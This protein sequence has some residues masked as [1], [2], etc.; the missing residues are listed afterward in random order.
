MNRFLLTVFLCISWTPLAF[1]AGDPWDYIKDGA[2][3]P[4]NWGGTCGTGKKQSPINI[5][6]HDATVD[7][8]L[9]SFM[10]KNYDMAPTN[11]TFTAKNNGHSLV[12]VFPE[13]ADYGVSGG[14]LVGNY[15]THSFHFHWGSNNTQGPEHILDGEKFGAELHFVSYNTKY[16]NISEAIA[17]ADGLA[18]LGVFLKVE[19][20]KNEAFSFLE[21]A[22]SLIDMSSSSNVTA[23]KLKP[24]LPSNK[25]KYFRYSGS[26]TTPRC[27][28]SVTWT[29]FNDAVKISQYQMDILRS[30]KGN[31]G[32][33]MDNN[34]RPVQPLNGRVVKASFQVPPLSLT[35]T[36]A[37]ASVV[38]MA[39][40]L[41]SL[42]LFAALFGH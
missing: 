11:G 38:N 24:M 10:L 39:T 30:L 19:G 36:E 5:K 25:T 4:S 26:L 3:G 22:K 18:V 32:A 7:K 42:M 34:Y 8:D 27:Y 16:S 23:F 2:H 29:V 13:N 35:P 14:G 9:G 33:S 15:K 17:K 40:G 28:E 6:G 31:N 20:D 41:F 12:F 37:G 1:S 21:D